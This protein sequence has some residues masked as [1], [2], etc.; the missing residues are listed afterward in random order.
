VIVTGT[1]TKVLPRSWR[2]PR[3]WWPHRRQRVTADFLAD[4]EAGTLTQVGGD[5][6]IAGE[7]IDLIQHL[8]H[9]DHEGD[10]Q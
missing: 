9:T 5:L 8:M 6:D 4:T 10:R 7:D 1:I 3:Y 2:R